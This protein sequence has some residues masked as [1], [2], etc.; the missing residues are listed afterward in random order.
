MP[1]T[2]HQLGK[3][4]CS[5]VLPFRA[6]GAVVKRRFR[7]GFL[8]K[9]QD[10]LLDPLHIKVQQAGS[11][12]QRALGK[13]RSNGMLTSD[14]FHISCVLSIPSQRPQELLLLL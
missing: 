9:F 1:Q 4:W 11:E 13:Q 6:M 2:C 12:T 3:G 14:T 7:M 5:D 8:R 10:T